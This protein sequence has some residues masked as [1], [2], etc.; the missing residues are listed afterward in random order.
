MIMTNK[1]VLISDSA[2]MSAMIERMADEI[3]EEFGSRADDLRIIGLQK[4]GVPLAERLS[5]AL[6][7]R[8]VTRRRIAADVLISQSLVGLGL[9]PAVLSRLFHL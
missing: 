9:A 3:A 2:E 6:E 1:A 5:V 8:F 4:R 7:K